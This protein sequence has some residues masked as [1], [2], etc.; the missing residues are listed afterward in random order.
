M[1]RVVQA[2]LLCCCYMDGDTSECGYRFTISALQSFGCGYTAYRTVAGLKY[3]MQNYGLVID[4]STVQMDD[5]R[6]IGRGR[7]MYFSFLP[8]QIIDVYFWAQEDVPK[9]AVRF[10]GLENGSYVNL[11]ALDEGDTV[12]IYRPN[13]NAKSVYIPYEYEACM[14]LFG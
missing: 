10:V 14:R 4:K 7:M 5:R 6:A 8:K 13:P 11:Y 3:F 1:L 9:D 2:P 12:R